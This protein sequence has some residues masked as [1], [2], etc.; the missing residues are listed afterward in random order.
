MRT[1]DKFQ[2]VQASEWH[3]APIKMCH[4]KELNQ[5]IELSMMII[6]QMLHYS[7]K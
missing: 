3:A 2:D 6:I 1:L 4:Y 7:S 5:R